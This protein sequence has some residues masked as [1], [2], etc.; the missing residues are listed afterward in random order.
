[1]LGFPG[2]SDSKGSAQNVG[3]LGSILASGRS[4]G[5]GNGKTLPYSCLENSMNREAW[6]AT[7]HGV[8]KSQARLR[9]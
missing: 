2:G 6:R 9:D 8:T 1:M 4:P 7:I 3:D 5:R